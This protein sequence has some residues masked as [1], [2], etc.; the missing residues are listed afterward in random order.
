MPTQDLKHRVEKANVN[1][2]Q[3]TSWRTADASSPSISSSTWSSGGML[4]AVEPL[5]SARAAAEP[6]SNGWA[7]ACAAELVTSAA[8]APDGAVCPFAA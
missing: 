6:A 1:T 4:L 2:W 8:P 5:A 7:A 3:R